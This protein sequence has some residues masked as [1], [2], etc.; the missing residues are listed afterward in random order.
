MKRKDTYTGEQLIQVYSNYLGRLQY[1]KLHQINQN[2]NI[3][4]DNNPHMMNKTSE[5]NKPCSEE[6]LSILLLHNAE[7]VK[8]LFQISNILYY[9]YLFENNTDEY[10]VIENKLNQYE[11]LLHIQ[12]SYFLPE[13]IYLQTPF[14]GL[15]LKLQVEKNHLILQIPVYHG[16]LKYFYSNY[17]DYFYL[18]KEDMAIHKNVAQYV[19]R[20]YRIKA[21]ASNCYTK[22]SGYF[23]PQMS[24]MITPSFKYEY[25]DKISFIESSNPL[26]TKTNIIQEY[27]HSFIQYVILNKETKLI[28]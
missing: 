14:G 28:S 7:D 9:T 17:K 22:Q 1:E 24:D 12:L 16:V 2:N 23:L 19:D 20:E 4:S 6:L 8:G 11:W 13:S 26:L 27:I 5:S 18:P 3:I 10:T 15:S 21:K 25:N